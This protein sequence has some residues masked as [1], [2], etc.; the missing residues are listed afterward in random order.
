VLSDLHQP[1]NIA[2]YQAHGIAV[3]VVAGDLQLALRGD[4]VELRARRDPPAPLAREDRPGVVGHATA[5]HET[6]SCAS[7]AAACA[8]DDDL[9]AIAHFFLGIGL[10]SPELMHA[11]DLTTM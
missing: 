7:R 8:L 9:V 1:V 11:G 2:P 6:A 10:H 4:E 3:Q 5:V